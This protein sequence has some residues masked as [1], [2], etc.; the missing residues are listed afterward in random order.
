MNLSPVLAFLAPAAIPLTDYMV[1]NGVIAAWDIAKLGPQPTSV[2]IATATAQLES[3][4]AGTAQLLATFQ[5]LPPGVQAFYASVQQA[6]LA[7][8]NAQN[9]SL[10][11][12]LIST[13]PAPTPAL[14]TAQAQLLALAQSVLPSPP[15]S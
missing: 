10:V 15:A 11:Q 13:A 5:A 3:I 2:Q 9:W 4:Q 8:I 14:V 7:A 6:I 1:V 12:A